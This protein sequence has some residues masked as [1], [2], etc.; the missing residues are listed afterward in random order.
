MRISDWSADVCSSDLLVR[1]FA[2]GGIGVSML[3]ILLYGFLRGSWL[4]AL[5][6]GVALAMSMLPEELPGVLTLFMTMSAL[7]MSRS[8]VLG[9]RGTAIEALGAATV[10]CTEKTG[11]LTQHRMPVEEMRLP[12]GRAFP[13]SEDHRSEHPSMLRHQIAVH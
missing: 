10:L 6:S 9:R 5:L 2:A 4:D 12:D 7:R 3:A 13:G 1:W 11:K 8:R